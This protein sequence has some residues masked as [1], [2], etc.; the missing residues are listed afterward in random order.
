MLLLSVR[1]VGPLQIVVSF[2]DNDRHRRCGRHLLLFVNYI[3]VV[4]GSDAFTWMAMKTVCCVRMQEWDNV[5][6]SDYSVLY[7]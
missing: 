6:I 2:G 7:Y 4:C 5:R 1:G 3:S